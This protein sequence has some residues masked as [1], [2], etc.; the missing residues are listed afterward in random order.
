MIAY[1]FEWGAK[2]G[3]LAVVVGNPIGSDIFGSSLINKKFDSSVDLAQESRLISHATLI[4]SKCNIHND[5]S[6]LPKY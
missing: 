5:F 2:E 4:N 3:G 6:I 1:I